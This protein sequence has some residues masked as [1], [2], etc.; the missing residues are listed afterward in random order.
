MA[1]TLIGSEEALR[2]LRK[3]VTDSELKA[4]LKDAVEDAMTWGEAE[5]EI[6]ESDIP[7]IQQALD[8]ME[9]HSIR[10]AG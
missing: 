6:H 10:W 3:E 5:V 2:F 8:V 1:K 9:G 4:Q 7:K